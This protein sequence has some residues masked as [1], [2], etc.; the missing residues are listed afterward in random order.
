MLVDLVL[1]LTVD[2]NEDPPCS[3]VCPAISC[4]VGGEVAAVV[5]H[6]VR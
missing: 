1:I 4:G 3:M 5:Q 2:Q 6:I